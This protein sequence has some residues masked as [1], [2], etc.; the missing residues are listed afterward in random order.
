[1][2]QPEFF[3]IPPSHPLLSASCPTNN[4]KTLPG[5]SSPHPRSPTSVTP[6]VTQRNS[7]FCSN[8]ET[9]ELTRMHKLSECVTRMKTSA[10]RGHEHTHT[11]MHA[12][13]VHMLKPHRNTEITRM[14]SRHGFRGLL[15][16]TAVYTSIHPDLFSCQTSLGCADYKAECLWF[17]HVTSRVLFLFFFFAFPLWSQRRNWSSRKLS[18]S[19]RFHV[20]HIFWSWEKTSLR[21]FINVYSFF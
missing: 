4:R 7:E 5:L 15:W 20:H 17:C 14:R 10:P 6:P 8:E 19:C 1:M 2:V 21:R 11:R 9:I 18:Y 16:I 3:F 13:R 12:W